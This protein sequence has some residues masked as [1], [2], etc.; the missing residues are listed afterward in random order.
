MTAAQ[1]VFI[2]GR[3]QEFKDPEALRLEWTAGLN[4]G[5]IQ[6]GYRT[7]P[8]DKAIAFPFYG[9]EL[10]RVT[11]EL[12][13]SGTGV[14]LEALPED[15]NTAGPLHPDTSK[16]VGDLERRLIADMALA[17]GVQQT[18]LE[19]F[20]DFILGWGPARAAL[21]LLAKK[22]RVDQTIISAYLRDVAV[23]LTHGRDA[24]QRIVQKVVPPTGQLILVTHSLGTVVARDLL[25][26]LGIRKRTKLWI[27]AGSPLGMDAVQ[28][29][30]NTEGTVNPGVP[31]FS[32]YDV[33]DIV[34]LGHPLRV[35]WKSPLTD[36]EVENGQEP[37]SI[38]KY[39]AHGE[40]A[41]PI[42]KALAG[43]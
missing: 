22:T 28:R 42:G 35:T 10:Y 29:N 38:T 16:A 12:A 5:L 27:T 18:R 30:L 40:V 11:A 32:A 1:L 33:N 21:N 39:L 3:S 2:H 31:W 24:I 9:N 20:G 36:V 13:R 14:R 6:A 4:A 37:H 17:A 43:T 7:L 25:D 26:D 19:G 41:G 15:P 8:D 34:A 23:Y